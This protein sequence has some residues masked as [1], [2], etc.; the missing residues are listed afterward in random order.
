MDRYEL[1]LILSARDIDP[2]SIPDRI[3]ATG[4]EGA[5]STTANGAIVLTIARQMPSLSTMIIAAVDDVFLLG[6]RV[7]SLEPHY[8]VGASEIASRLGI[9]A[10]AITHRQ[11]RGGAPAFPPPVCRVQ[12]DRP[13]Y[14]WFEIASWAYR[15]GKLDWVAVRHATIMREANL[16]V[17]LY[18]NS[19][20]K[21]AAKLRR[22]LPA[23]EAGLDVR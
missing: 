5:S 12:A 15:L 23:L 13:L 21:L 9:S 1:T 14:D 17:A 3:I 4:L 19:P 20:A 16:L 11:Q 22:C 18:R 2:N 6:S 8:L 7:E 10:A